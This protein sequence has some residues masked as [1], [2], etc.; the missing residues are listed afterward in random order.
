MRRENKGREKKGGEKEEGGRRKMSS[1]FEPLNLHTHSPTLVAAEVA[2][3]D[4]LELVHNVVPL[5]WKTGEREWDITDQDHKVW[6]EITVP[7]LLAK[8]L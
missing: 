6:N 1:Y 4:N 7:A 3:M 5:D 2:G 8:L